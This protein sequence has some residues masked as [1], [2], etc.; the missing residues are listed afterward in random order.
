MAVH[1][2]KLEA[3]EMNAHLPQIGTLGLV[4]RMSA[5]ISPSLV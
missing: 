4:R 5:G 1:R 2:A 3:N